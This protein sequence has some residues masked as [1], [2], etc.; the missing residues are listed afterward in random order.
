MDK[1]HEVY[2]LTE[3][4]NKEKGLN[5][6][7]FYRVSSFDNDTKEFIIQFYE[8]TKKNGI[9]LQNKIPNPLDSNIQYY[10]TIIGEEFKVNQAF[11]ILNFQK[12]IPSLS[13]NSAK[14]MALEIYLLMSELRNLGKTDGILKSVYIK[15]MCWLYYSFQNI[16]V[17]AS[18]GIKT[19]V[20]FNGN[21]SQ[22]E[23]NILNMLAKIGC[24]V[25]VVD[26]G[27]DYYSKLDPNNTKSV[28]FNC[29]GE[30]SLKLEDILDSYNK[31]SKLDSLVQSITYKRNTN[32]CEISDIF[33]ELSNPYSYR[34]GNENQY[35][36]YFYKL[37]GVDDVV[38]FKSKVHTFLKNLET[39]NYSVICIEG[40]LLSPLPNEISQI[41]ISNTTDK[42]TLLKSAVE[43]INCSYNNTIEKIIKNEIALKFGSLLET[44]S[45]N[46]LKK[47]IV[48]V[49]CWLNRYNEELFKNYNKEQLPVIIVLGGCSN[50]IQK[51]FI[52][53][54]SKL[55]IDVILLCPNKNI[56]ELSDDLELKT[57]EYEYSLEMNELPS[58]SG[59]VA[60]PTVSYV[61]S[62]DIDDILYSDGTMFRDFQH[63]TA[64]S[65]ILQTTFE[66]IKILWQQPAQFRPNFDTTNNK[67]VVPVIC[68]K[69]NGIVGNTVKE[70]WKEVKNY[71]TKDT[72]IMRSFNF[73]NKSQMGDI[74]VHATQFFKNGKLLR[75]V[76][77]NHSCYKYKHLREE[78]QNHILDKLE[79]LILSKTIKG[80]L[81]FGVE[82]KIISVILGLDKNME[83]MLHKYDFNKEIPKIIVITTDEVDSSLE[84]AILLAFFSLVGFDI[85]IFSSSGY[86]KL[87]HDFNKSIFQQ[88]KCGELMYD[89]DIPD[90]KYVDTKRPQFNLFKRGK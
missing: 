41:N 50:H 74:S 56:N 33:T 30:L 17:N 4:F 23:L 61:A 73:V 36:N 8:N 52:E 67:L 21:L 48:T 9:F 27:S 38:Y 46:S 42:F 78:M 87:E 34:G 49:I 5:E 7:F 14:K 31:N 71:I 44:E 65:I 24:D 25:V 77:K 85:V 68:A 54:I 51:L 35:C 80:T 28:N 63:G 70:H 19:C 43:S 12:W 84:D 60:L 47:Q 16:V 6:I 13:L 10:S 58:L 22:H 53:I 76:I 11:F 59:S 89:L 81:E 55:P 64:T 15:Y 82:Y 20:L 26:D 79:L 2:K 69:V 66:E 90:L 75:N 39:L 29:S 45:I 40:D 1:F 32:N 88:H 3:Y 37:L 72:L 18:N 62:R 86:Q 57:I 83:R